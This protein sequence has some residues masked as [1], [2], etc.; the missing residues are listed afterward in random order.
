MVRRPWLLAGGVFGLLL[1][2]YAVLWYLAGTERFMA[3]MGALASEKGAE[4]L[5]TRVEVGEVRVDSLRSLT[6]RNIALYD[7]Q[8]ELLLKAESASVRFSL[9]GMLTDVPARAVEEVVVRRPEA[10][11]EKRANG[12][13]NYEDLV[14]EDSEPSAFRGVV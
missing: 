2:A 13:W 3:D 8:N 6:I 7:K 12:R 1:F 4:I 9:F 14:E 5:D 11:I 10:R